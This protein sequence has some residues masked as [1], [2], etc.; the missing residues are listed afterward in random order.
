MPRE[1]LAAEV[2]LTETQETRSSAEGRAGG[3]ARVQRVGREKQEPEAERCLG[4][5]HGALPGR[6][7]ACMFIPKEMV[8]LWKVREEAQ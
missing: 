1:G 5:E 6:G 8:A 3:V 2:S 7:L 4:P